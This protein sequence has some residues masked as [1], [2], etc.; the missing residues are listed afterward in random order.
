MINGRGGTQPGE[1]PG[2]FSG[3]AVSAAG[4]VNGDGLADIIVGAPFSDLGYN[5]TDPGGDTGDSFV[6]FGKTNVEAVNLSSVAAGTGGFVILGRGFDDQ[7]NG[8]GPYSNSNVSAAGDVNGDGLA[9]LIVGEQYA[10]T[11]DNTRANAGRS[12]IIFGKTDTS[13][14]A[15]SK[16]EDG[17]SS[18]TFI[19]PNFTPTAGHDNFAGSSANDVLIGGLGDD[20]L[21][22]NG[23]IDVLYG[24]SGNDTI[25]INASNIAALQFGQLGL[26]TQEVSDLLYQFSR[27]DGGLGIDTLRVSGNNLNLNLSAIAKSSAGSPDVGSRIA[28]IEK[29]D[30]ATEN[31]NNTLSLSARDVLDISGMNVFNTGNGWSNVGADTSFSSSVKKHQLVVLGGNNDTVDIEL[32]DWTKAGR[33]NDGVSDYDVWNHFSAAAQLIIQQTITVM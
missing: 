1:Y 5:P 32:S 9:D 11:I 19:R 31:T 21:T 23:G 7:T 17:A 2:D 13:A 25:V 15:L 26:N 16:I 3:Y 27:V 6:V 18:N 24:G 10:E 33:V 29:I 14:V 8:V 20:T 30:F 28:S 4:D 12:F 22:G